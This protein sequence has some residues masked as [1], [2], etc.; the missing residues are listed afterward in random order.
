[1][2]PPEL[3]LTET[4]VSNLVLR[5]R[6]VQ[7]RDAVSDPNSGSNPID[8]GMIDALQTGVGDLSRQVVRQHISELSPQEQI[9]LVAMF[10]IGRGDFEP[11]EWVEAVK[12]AE[13]QRETPTATYILGQP[14][15]ADFIAEGWDKLEDS[16]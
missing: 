3:I 16:T 4:V 6:G 12:T 9:E 11:A 15:A 2:E 14:L 13:E 10:W 1:M 8:D 5:L 7:G